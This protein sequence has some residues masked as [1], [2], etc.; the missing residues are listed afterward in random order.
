MT[1]E[2]YNLLS[3]VISSVESYIS[4]AQTNLGYNDY[5]EAKES[6][7]KAYAAF[8]TLDGALSAEAV[9][10]QPEPMD[11]SLVLIIAVIVIIAVLAWFLFKKFRARLGR[12]EEG[13]FEGEE[14]FGEEF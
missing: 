3:D 12:K 6:Y 11:M 8:T 14:E 4:S 10:P 9:I 1:T 2:Q 7:D 13:E 5:A